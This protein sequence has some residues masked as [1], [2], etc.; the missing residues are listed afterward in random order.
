MG[1]SSKAA[2]ASSMSFA[3]AS[4]SSCSVIFLPRT[5]A[6]IAS[7]SLATDESVYPVR[8]SGT[9]ASAASTAV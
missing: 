9:F 7:F 6:L 8:S 5:T 3:I 4:T 1:L 2:M